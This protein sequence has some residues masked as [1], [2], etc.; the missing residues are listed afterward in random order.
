MTLVMKNFWNIIVGIFAFIGVVTVLSVSYAF[1][2]NN[3]QIQNCLTVF[4][5]KIREPLTSKLQNEGISVT[6]NGDGAI[7]YPSEHE[8]FVQDL[9]KIIFTEQNPQ[10]LIS[11]ASGQF[12]YEV[13]NRLD[14]ENIKYAILDKE[15][16][17]KL[18][19]EAEED[20][21]KA[22]NIIDQTAK[23]LFSDK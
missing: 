20:M 11:I 4:A 9:V 1:I 17:I 6:I 16:Q 23:D 14:A 19:I 18:K 10:N 13:F 2:K 15:G 5:T 3:N 8:Q 12:A 21:P 22:L 7:C